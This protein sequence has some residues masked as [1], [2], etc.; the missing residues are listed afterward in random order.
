M[1]YSTTTNWLDI[2]D[3]CSVSA[4]L[5]GTVTPT[6]TLDL[7][8]TNSWSKSYSGPV[9][10]VSQYLTALNYEMEVGFSEVGIA[11]VFALDYSLDLS[12]SAKVSVI[13]GVN[14]PIAVNYAVQGTCANGLATTFHTNPTVQVITPVIS[15]SATVSAT[16]ALSP[17]IGIEFDSLVTLS[18]AASPYISSTTTTTS[19]LCASLSVGIN[20]QVEAQLDGAVADIVDG[21]DD[22]GAHIPTS[23]TWPFTIAPEKQIWQSC[24]I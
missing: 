15:G 4:S 17:S 1:S 11:P 23:W 10:G 9:P 3:G 21:L 18:G 2:P 16:L 5:T 7:V 6:I 20:G 12:A 14:V 22:F 8:L 24:R 13:A 19:G